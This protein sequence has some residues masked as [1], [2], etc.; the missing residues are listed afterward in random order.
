MDLLLLIA[1]IAVALAVLSNFDEFDQ[2][3]SSITWALVCS[4]PLALLAAIGGWSSLS[5]ASWWKRY[6]PLVGFTVSVPWGF[7]WVVDSLFGYIEDGDHGGLNCVV[8]AAVMWAFTAFL[9]YAFWL[10]REV[11]H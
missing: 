9:V 6:L 1:A 5:N 11:S 2:N 3:P 8:F 4:I 10:Y 7:A